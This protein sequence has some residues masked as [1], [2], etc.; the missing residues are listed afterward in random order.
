MFIIDKDLAKAYQLILG[1]KVFNST[2][3]IDNAKEKL[4]KLMIKFH[5]SN[6]IGI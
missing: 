6:L 5:N 1:Y 2:A 3:T 4:E